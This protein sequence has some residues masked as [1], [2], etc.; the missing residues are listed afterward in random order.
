MRG[1]LFCLL[2]LLTIPL[3]AQQNSYYQIDDRLLVETK[4]KYTYALHLESNTIIHKAEDKYDFYLY[5][6]YNFTYEQFLNDKL[7]KGTWSLS[8]NELFYSFKQIRKFTIA[9]INKNILVLE[10]TQPN[11]KGTYQYHFMRVRSEQAPFVKPWNELPDVNVEAIDE[12]KRKKSKEERWVF[13]KKRKQRDAEEQAIKEGPYI[14]VELVGG[15]YYGGIDPVLRDF[16]MIKNTGRL[17]KEFK[18]INNGLVVTKKDISRAEL[19]EFIAY[20]EDK[21]FFSFERKYDCETLE[22]FKRKQ[23][24]PTPIPL[25]LVIA[26]GERRKVITIS[27]WGKDEYG[28]QYVEYP[29][30]LDKIIESIQRMANRMEQ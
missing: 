2:L 7:T 4:W 12:R 15:G 1:G 30:A 18:S 8:D 22:C 16:I 9:Q 19:E 27:I 23:E 14:N 24:R 29:P 17:I 20:V 26:H 11:S 13:G 6:R 3:F 21:D 10:F 25:R 28:T 5:F